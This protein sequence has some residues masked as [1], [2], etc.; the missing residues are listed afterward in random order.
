MNTRP[1]RGENRI[2]TALLLIL[3][4]GCVISVS[5]AKSQ[6]FTP[7]QAVSGTL[8]RDRLGLSRSCVDLT[9]DRITRQYTQSKMSRK[10]F[11]A[12]GGMAT[13]CL[14]IDQNQAHE[15]AYTLSVWTDPLWG[16][17]VYGVPDR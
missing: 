16:R 8:C 11:G 15:C 1:Q 5:P 3:L 4:L 17:V 6:T 7:T 10:M 14:R 9:T 12:I 13:N 2:R